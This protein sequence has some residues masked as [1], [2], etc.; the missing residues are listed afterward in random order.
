MHKLLLLT[1]SKDLQVY[2]NYLNAATLPDLEIVEEPDQEVDMVFGEPNLIRPVLASLPSLK[3]VQATWAG[4][5]PLLDPS[6]IRN[7]T[8]TNARGV[9]GGLMTEYVFAYLL[10]HERKILERLAAQHDHRWEPALT[11]TLRGK[12]IG[13]LGVGS[14][15]SH[16]AESARYFGMHVRGFTFKSE[17]CPFVDK[18]YHS[19]N[20]LDF[21][22]DLDVLVNVLP[23]TP[24][25]KNII[26]ANL[27]AQL[28][29]HAILINAGR[30]SAVNESA[31]IEALKQG[32][33]AMAVLDVFTQEPL[34]SDH[35]FWQAP[36]LII[37]SHT[38]APS[39]PHDIANIFIDNYQAYRQ[40]KPLKYQVNFESG[41]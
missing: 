21:A 30:G 36:N 33:L 22:S 35:A 14:I 13:L 17:N 7:Y 6:L 28:P 41:Y 8:L 20:L 37:T 5:E 4:V 27:L 25:T 3:W 11:G 40:G 38:A 12:T 9:F 32:N 1:K 34:P 39:F 19:Q 16:L 24:L 26:D 10:M 31:L 23:N 29:K 15:G 2:K 18:Y